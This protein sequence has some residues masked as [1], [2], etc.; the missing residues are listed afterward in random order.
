MSTTAK[1]LLSIMTV[2]LGMQEDG[3]TNPPQSIK[4]ATRQLVANLHL[5]SP[6]EKIDI[7]IV[8]TDPIHAKYVRI[9]TG[10]VLAEVRSDQSSLLIGNVLRQ[11]SA[12][13]PK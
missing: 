5:L 11:E 10:Q 8:T 6:E 13:D 2:R 12:S 7:V 1:Q 4:D 3:V 9:E